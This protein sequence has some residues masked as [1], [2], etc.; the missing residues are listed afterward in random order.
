VIT[1][2]GSRTS[3][4]FDAGQDILVAAAP[5]LHAVGQSRVDLELEDG[6]VLLSVPVCF[7]RLAN[8]VGAADA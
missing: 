7:L 8:T 1:A 5:N 6:T 3:M 2:D 4:N